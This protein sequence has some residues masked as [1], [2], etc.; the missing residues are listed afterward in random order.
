MQLPVEFEYNGKPQH[1][2]RKDSTLTLPVR[3]IHSVDPHAPITTYTVPPSQYRKLHRARARS[4]N[5][6][7]YA[8]KSLRLVPDDEIGVV[9]THNNTI[10]LDATS[11]NVE[12]P[13]NINHE[14]L[15]LYPN[16]V[17]FHDLVNKPEPEM[18]K[19]AQYTTGQLIAES[20]QSHATHQEQMNDP[21]FVF[22]KK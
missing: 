20:D 10:Y 17:Q 15:R 9:M 13:T 1:R 19:P 5:S 18:E 6:G 7:L 16:V 8:G 22:G 11:A 3:K 2:S 14:R 12:L 21:S 4:H